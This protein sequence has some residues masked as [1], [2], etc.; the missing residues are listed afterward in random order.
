MSRILNVLRQSPQEASFQ[1]SPPV[2][3][4]LADADRVYA[5]T[6]E[7]PVE[8]TSAFVNPISSPVNG[9]SSV[10]SVQPSLTAKSRAEALTHPDDFAAEQFRVLS[11]RLQNLAE[12]GSLKTLLVTSASF[13]EGKSLVCLNLAIT[14]AQRPGKKVLLVEGDLRK[15]A[16][17]SM[18]GVPPRRGLT[19][20]VQ[21][22]EPLNNFLCR[23]A[24][25]NLW[26]LPAGESCSQHLEAIQSSRLRELPNEAAKHFDW[27][28][29]DS[30][31]LL[32]AD[33]GILS[34]LA[35]GTLVVVRQ[36]STN[37]KTVQKS[38]A[39]LERVLGFVL[40]HASS[41]NPRDYDQYYTPGKTNGNGAGRKIVNSPVM[42][43][44]SNG[45]N[46]SDGANA[47]AS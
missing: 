18:L 42:P 12:M 24:D 40:N 6:R 13:R 19:D 45:A 36:E 1:N 31:P 8:T 25:L 20:W 35:D 9:L 22:E 4:A 32:V 44:G 2:D 14:L 34:R 38:L 11:A 29:V 21:S 47:V 7:M 41:V 5:D 28:V 17:C 3:A 15:P 33:A 39:S 43:S 37:K 27:I 30:S 10:V 26:F 16:L 46:P 23:L